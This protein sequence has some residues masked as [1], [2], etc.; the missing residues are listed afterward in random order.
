MDDVLIAAEERAERVSL[1]ESDEV[2]LARAR[3]GRLRR[4]TAGALF[5]VVVLAVSLVAAAI[6]ERDPAERPRRID[7]LAYPPETTLPAP[8]PCPPPRLAPGA[9]PAIDFID[10]VHVGGVSYVNRT[11]RPSNLS[12]SSIGTRVATVCES[13]LSRRVDSSTRDGDASYLAEGTPIYTLRGYSAKFRLA[14]ERNGQLVIFEAD[15]N[16]N[17]KVG[18]DLIDLSTVPVQAVAV[19]DSASGST[20]ARIDDLPTIGRLIRLLHAAPV[21]QTRQPIDG[22]TSLISFEFPDGTSTTRILWLDAGFM[23]SGI[24][25]GPEFVDI[26]RNAVR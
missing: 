26:I 20:I 21:D 9:N 1:P 4:R 7:T 25:V 15:A 14:A 16:P 12:T 23:G 13:Y 8:A 6:L 5:A 2:P 10:F 19:Q 11:K 3:V 22:S 18:R 24:V 17:A